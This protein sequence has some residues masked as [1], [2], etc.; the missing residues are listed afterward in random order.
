M[1]QAMAHCFMGAVWRRRRLFHLAWE[2]PNF[3]SSS[4]VLSCKS[5]PC[6]QSINFQSRPLHYIFVRAV[7]QLPLHIVKEVCVLN[8]ARADLT[9]SQP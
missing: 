3:V 9:K 8:G 4:F 6:F 1:S 7:Y 5:Q 2:L